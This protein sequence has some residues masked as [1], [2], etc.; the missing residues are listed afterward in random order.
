M[1]MTRQLHG[2]M[3]PDASMSVN[4]PLFHISSWSGAENKHTNWKCPSRMVA[5]MSQSIRMSTHEGHT[6]PSGMLLGR[7][8]EEAHPGRNVHA[9]TRT[10]LHYT[11]GTRCSRRQWVS[12]PISSRSILICT[13]PNWLWR[14]ALRTWQQWRPQTSFPAGNAPSVAG[15]SSSCSPRN[16]FFIVTYLQFT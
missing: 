6:S 4:S 1:Q 16:S 3:Q 14:T 10:D 13:R 5:F 15:R 12:L 9:V 11:R 8:P 7:G 2:L